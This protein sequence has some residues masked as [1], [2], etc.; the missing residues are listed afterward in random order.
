MSRSQ[1][2]FRK[3][4]VQN[5]KEKKRKDKEQKR[6]ARKENKSGGGLDDMIAYVDEYG[7]IS[8]TPPDPTKKKKET[9]LEDI[10]IGVP[11]KEDIPFDPIRRGIL[12]FFNDSKGYGFIKDSETEEKL[13]IHASN[14]IDDIRE[15]NK[16]IFEIEK[17]PKGPVAVRVKL[18]N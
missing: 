18:D 13:F 15:N 5:K 2:T 16:V 17:G 10:E 8:S 11:K 9:K 14:M 7:R 4:E 3:K 12:L 6:L 1:Q